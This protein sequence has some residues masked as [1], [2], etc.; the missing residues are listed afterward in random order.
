MILTELEL[1]I[2]L[3]RIIL[4]YFIYKI[5]PLHLFLHSKFAY[6]ML[7]KIFKLCFNHF[8]KDN[9]W[10]LA[11]QNGSLSKFEMTFEI[12]NLFPFRSYFCPCQESKCFEV[13]ISMM[14]TFLDW[15]EQY[16][17]FLLPFLNYI[18]KIFFLCTFRIYKFKI[19]CTMKRHLT[20]RFFFFIKFATKKNLPLVIVEI[21][22]QNIFSS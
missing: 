12:I 8:S 5:R 20:V 16:H 19:V 9:Q 18:I 4:F 10:F 14:C 6:W 15:S 17:H 21:I 22:V 3:L 2:H 13:M 1:T 11:L 7:K